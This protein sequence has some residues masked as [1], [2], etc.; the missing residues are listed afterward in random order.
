MRTLGCIVT[1]AALAVAS[2]AQAQK[3]VNPDWLEKPS[4]ADI[5]EHFPKLA[6]MLSIEGRALV[7]CEVSAKGLL[8]RCS[9]VSEVP[10]G[11]GFGPAAQVLAK[12]FKMTPKTV[13]GKPVAGGEI[14]IPIRF[15]LPPAPP[16]AK[17]TAKSDVFGAP[18]A[19]AL[20]TARKI[21]QAQDLSSQ[22]RVQFEVGMM[23]LMEAKWP[24]VEDKTR[25]DGIEALR[26][27]FAKFWEAFETDLAGAYAG[28]FSE[29]ELTDI[30]AFV[31][32]PSGRAFTARQPE[33]LRGMQASVAA[34]LK[35][36][37]EAARTAFCAQHP[38]SAAPP[39]A[40]P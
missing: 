10:V 18:S 12:T 30:A 21:V 13:D 31:T 11:L 19:Q 28:A 33:I 2:G 6:Q 37:S 1:A 25:D 34:S 27:G 35:A 23:P 26:A 29:A 14:R 39:P 40:T 8:D 20:E 3:V 7:A 24:G 15:T 4:G 38:C 16:V 22:G 17:L 5:A 36:G 9:V 32:S